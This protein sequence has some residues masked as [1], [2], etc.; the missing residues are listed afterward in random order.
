[1]AESSFSKK[2][3]SNTTFLIFDQIAYKIGTVVA[4]IVLVRLL[5]AESIAVIGIASGYLIVIGYLDI[6]LV[7]VLLRDYPKIARDPLERNLHFTAYMLFVAL[8]A[9]LMLL[10]ALGMELL[11]LRPLNLPGLLFLYTALTFEFMALMFQDWIK[12]VFFT[13]LQQ[14]FAT[15]ISALVTVLRLVS[16]GLI[17]FA[18]SL[19]TYSWILIGVSIGSIVLWGAV[20]TLRFDF[21]PVFSRRIGEVLKHA[22]NSYGIWDHLNRIAA[23]TLFNVDTAILTYFASLQMISDYSIALKVASLLL[24]LPRQLQRGLQVVLANY[25]TDRER[26][27]AI[28]TFFKANLLLSLGQFAGIAIFG[29]LLIRLMFG[30][31]DVDAIYHYTIII[32]LGI[33]VLCVAHP[34]M[35]IINNFT[36]LKRAFLYVSLP[37][38]AGG[39]LLFTGG[40]WLGSADGIAWAKVAVFVALSAGLA[41][42][43]RRYF[44]FPLHIEFITHEEKRLLRELVRRPEETQ[45]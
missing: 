44:P 35:S 18:P 15:K 30:E 28:N 34:F 42:F 21:R 31:V 14:V 9:I 29:R 4:F 40:A 5:A 17:L 8:Q 16:Y 26:F 7:R 45:R 41:W 19:E 12:L 27:S 23:D 43:A 6:S 13:D 2:I 36:S 33:S 37:A 24:L 10:V 11:V 32:T 20:F 22:F 25:E 3:F 1:M 39:L 38:L